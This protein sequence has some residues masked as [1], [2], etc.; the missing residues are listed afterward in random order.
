ML[1]VREDEP[2][3]AVVPAEILAPL[4]APAI[5]LRDTQLPAPE[6]VDTVR[7]TRDDGVVFGFSQLDGDVPTLQ[8]IDAEPQPAAERWDVPALRR[9]QDWL[10]SPRAVQWTPRVEL[11]RGPVARLTTG[12]DAPAYTVNVGQ[13]LAQRTDLPGVFRIAPEIAALFDAEYR[14]GC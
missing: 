2:V 5:T 8:V 3:A 1:A 14:P 10:Q 11:P 4:L 6:G 7:L 12:P 13:N 9:L